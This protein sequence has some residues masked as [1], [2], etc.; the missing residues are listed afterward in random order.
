MRHRLSMLCLLLALAVHPAAASTVEIREVPP[1]VTPPSALLRELAVESWKLIQSFESGVDDLAAGW[2]MRL[3]DIYPA[4]I[5]RNC[6]PYQLALGQLGFARSD[7]DTAR[8]AFER[9]VELESDA[10]EPQAWLALLELREG[11]LTAA[12]SR[13]HRALELD[14]LQD[15]AREVVR[16]TELVL[17]TEAA[18]S[19][20]SPEA[21]QAVITGDAAF[22]AGDYSVAAEAY[23][24]ALTIDPGFVEARVY[25]GDALL[26]GGEPAAALAE[27]ESALAYAPDNAKAHYLSGEALRRLSRYAEA[28]AALNRALELRPGYTAAAAALNSLPDTESG[29]S[30]RVD[31]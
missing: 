1:L 12:L 27:L 5:R 15:L 19:T 25:L 10:A 11:R 24:H 18:F 9:A 22:A 31:D 17:T 3:S 2:L 13:A 26:R 28:A 23:H 16:V 14:P 6:Y 8:L 7:F 30:H 20:D 29:S 4:E 21:I